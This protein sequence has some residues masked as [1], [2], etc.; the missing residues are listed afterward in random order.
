MLT[1]KEFITS[2]G[3]EILHL[4]MC[5]CPDSPTNGGREAKLILKK[6]SEMKTDIDFARFSESMN[7]WKKKYAEHADSC[8]L[9]ALYD[10]YAHIKEVSGLTV[11]GISIIHFFSGQHHA[12]KIWAEILNE[13]GKDW[14][15]I[16]AR[17]VLFA[18]MLV[19]MRIESI[20]GDR[21]HGV[22]EDGENIITMRNVLSFSDDLQPH[23]V[24]LVHYG[25]VL[26]KASKKESENT[27]R[28][29]FHSGLFSETRK[30]IRDNG[31]DFEDMHYFPRSL[32]IAK[33]EI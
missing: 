32:K 2:D 31:I 28:G 3:L 7:A 21:V 15:M 29:N 27:L 19:V 18:H 1:K 25:F 26:K 24:V 12:E 33:G 16:Y 4:V 23:D 10:V 20:E 30:L 8:L 9:D 5:S 22:Y 6:F 11:D 17:K 13:H 14:G